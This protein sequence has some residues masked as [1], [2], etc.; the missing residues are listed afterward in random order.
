MVRN[1][2]LSIPLNTDTHIKEPASN[3]YKN[4]LQIKNNCDIG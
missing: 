4:I 1:P 2:A 3:G